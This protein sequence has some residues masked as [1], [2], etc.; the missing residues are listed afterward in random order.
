MKELLK[1]NGQFRVFLVYQ[2]FSGL[3]NGIFNLFMLLRDPNEKTEAKKGILQNYRADLIE[4]MKFLRKNVLLFF[5]AA[6]IAHS[7]LGQASY[8][9]RPAFIEY[10]A[11]ARGYIILTVMMMAGGLIAS[12]LVTP[13]GK[14]FRV[15]Q[16]LFGFYLFAG[17]SR[18]V[19]AM[20]LPMSFYLAIGLA[21]VNAAVLSAS[22]MVENSLAQKL[23][24]K[25]M[26]G[27]VDTMSTSFTAASFALG[28]L[29]G[30]VLGS[31]VSDLA[32]IFIAQGVIFAVASVYY[33]LV[34]EIRKMPKFNDILRIRA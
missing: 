8:V 12:S 27:R 30:G 11:G 26:V 10:H 16:L 23:P 20:V 1:T 32:Y 9:N 18:I 13:L 5:I 33:F 19:F 29:A 34:P 3:G 22:T 4:V 2:M 24:P 17:V 14:I 7:F 6:D 25:E 31:V 15:S 28:A 21:I